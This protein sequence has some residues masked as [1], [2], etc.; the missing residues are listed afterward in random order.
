MDYGAMLRN[1]NELEAD[2]SVACMHVPVTEASAFGIM[3]IDKQS[4]VIEFEEKPE[5]PT[6]MP[7]EKPAM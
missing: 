7:N 2:L 3:T 1:H 4:R 5:N 6:Y